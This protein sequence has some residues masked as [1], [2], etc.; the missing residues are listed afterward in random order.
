MALFWE[1]LGAGLAGTV[2]FIIRDIVANSKFFDKNKDGKLSP[3][4]VGEYFA[5]NWLQL[6]AIL[7]IAVIVAIPWSFTG[8][9]GLMGPI[10]HLLSIPE[11]YELLLYFS[12]G[13]LWMIVQS[14]YSKKFTQDRQ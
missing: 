4:E 8:G 12:P 1:Q 5:F 3:R 14:K 13:L 9:E 7:V 11:D 10:A 2:L 6:I